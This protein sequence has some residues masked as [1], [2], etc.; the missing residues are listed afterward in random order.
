MAIP[1]AEKVWQHSVNT[2]AAGTAVLNDDNRSVLFAIK[3]ALTG[4]SPVTGRSLNWTN[5]WTVVLSSDG[6]S[7]GASDYWDSTPDLVW[8]TG[9]HSWIVLRQPI[10]GI[11][12]CLDLSNANTGYMTQVWSPATGFSGGDTSNRPT[13]GD[14]VILQN[15]TT[16]L[17]G[18]NL[19]YGARVHVLSSLDGMASRVLVSVTTSSAAVVCLFWLYDQAKDPVSG[20][21]NYNVALSVD[22][23]VSNPVTSHGYLANSARVVGIPPSGGT[24]N[25]YMSN[26][27]TWRTSL[28]VKGIVKSNHIWAPNDFNGEWPMTTIG[29]TSQTSGAIGRHGQLYDIWFGSDLMHGKTYPNNLTNKFAQF[30]NI[31]VPWNGEGVQIRR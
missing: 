4:V 3:Q 31:V 20:W 2:K 25:M 13:A 27:S 10:T 1:V 11:E 14:Q 5:P 24:M 29:L 9:T 6:V 17:G 21:T 18:Q 30:H 22:D 28:G 8:G 23:S 15:N 26:E 7:A 12:V 19:A 16:W